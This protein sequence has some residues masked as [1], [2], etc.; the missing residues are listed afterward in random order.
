LSLQ[1]IIIVFCVDTSTGDE[2]SLEE[3]A[4]LEVDLPDILWITS[5]LLSARG[6]GDRRQ[7]I[8]IRIAAIGDGEYLDAY[9]GVLA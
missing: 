8:H 3:F 5:I 7:P 9:T 1:Y 2:Q 6:I 4:D